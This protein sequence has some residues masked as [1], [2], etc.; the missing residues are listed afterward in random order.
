MSFFSNVLETSHHYGGYVA[1]FKELFRKHEVSFGKQE[2]FFQLAPKLAYDSEFRAAFAGLTESVKKREDGKLTL[3]RILTIIAIA[4]GGPEIETLGSASAVPIS[5][6]VVFLAGVGGWSETELDIAAK[7][8]NA[9][10]STELKVPAA[11][12]SAAAGNKQEEQREPDAS[13]QRLAS[14][15]SHNL[16]ELTAS[17]FAGPALVKEALSRLELNTL[18]LKHH[19]DSIDQRIERIE[20]PKHP[21]QTASKIEPP[22]DVRPRSEGDRRP[23][24]LLEELAAVE[25][26]FRAR[27][28]PGEADASNVVDKSAVEAM[29]RAAKLNAGE[30]AEEQAPFP[31]DRSAVEAMFRAAELEKTESTKERAPFSVVDAILRA[32]ELEKAE[33]TKEQAPFSVDTSAVDAMLRAAESEKTGPTE[34]QA[35]FAV[36]TSAVEAMRAAESEKAAPFSA[37]TSAVEVILRA[38]ELEKAEPTKEQAPFSVDTSA[39][40]AILRAAE[41][42][43]AEPTKEQAPFSVDTS[44]VDA[45]LRA[46][47]L[48]K[49]EPTKEQA[50]F[51]VDTSAVDAILRAAESEKAEPTKEQAPF[52]VDTS[53]ID[54]IL[55][56][57]ESEPVEIDAPVLADRYKAEVVPHV[58]EVPKEQLVAPVVEERGAVKKKFEAIEPLFEPPQVEAA[59][60]VP[61]VVIANK[62]ESTRV[63]R[64]HRMI[65]VLGVLLFL[66]V[67]FAAALLYRD[68]DWLVQT[69]VKNRGAN[70]ASFASNGNVGLPPP[71]PGGGTNSN[72]PAR[73]MQRSSVMTPQTQSKSS[74]NFGQGELSVGGSNGPTTDTGSNRKVQDQAVI[75]QAQ[76][77]GQTKPPPVLGSAPAKIPSMKQEP[78]PAVAAAGPGWMVTGLPGSVSGAATRS[79]ESATGTAGNSE[80]AARSDI[81]GAPPVRAT[82]SKP[83][84]VPAPEAHV[85]RINSRVM[86]KNL[87]DSPKPTYPLGARLQRVEGDVLV[88]VL[89]SENGRVEKATAVSGPQPLR[90]VAES[91]IQQWRYKSY[92]V[93]GRPVKV[94]TDVNFH[95]TLNPE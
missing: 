78:P 90:G 70:A 34:E 85:F 61:P 87:I 91:A 53:A 51:S 7:A 46:A 23:T 27:K 68:R 43:K 71:D 2:D 62:Y 92:I 55:R 47:E 77:R 75:N 67:G 74:R 39:V 4:M 50:P 56:A 95:F 76:A 5:L 72:A 26:S 35:L 40:D 58:S 29:L 42:E 54:A 30:P 1:E 65:A 79:A 84:P 15:P 14:G 37:D 3:T 12:R 86:S 81:P 20:P 25:A 44:A 22:P 16:N 24:G 6:V 89:I 8:P 36:D 13:E 66:V 17:L 60:I 88:R 94:Q 41:S 38:A 57:A 69:F 11:D 63:Q 48:E 73:L 52:S 45:I 93:D 49:A 18:E 28:L 64:L 9:Q 59:P 80:L 82:L 21:D 33:P 83:L 31:V 19:L 32:A 10:A